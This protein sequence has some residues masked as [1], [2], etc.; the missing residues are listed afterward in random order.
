MSHPSSTTEER[1]AAIV[2]ALL[3]TPD[4]TPPAGTWF[5]SSGLRWRGKI[6]AMLSPD[7][8]FVVKLPRQRVDALIASG[9]GKRFD[10]GHGRLMKEWL[11]VEPTSAEEWLPLAREALA[12][13]AGRR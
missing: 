13:V 7:G 1:F 2:E 3:G 6:F 12:F 9:D 8:A 11:T 5:G 10:P 4:V